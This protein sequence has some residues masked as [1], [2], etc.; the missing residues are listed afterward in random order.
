MFVKLIGSNHIQNAPKW[1]DADGKI[2]SNPSEETLLSHGYKPLSESAKPVKEGYF[3][4]FEYQ[5]KDNYIE[6]VWVEHEIEPE[7]E[8]EPVVEENEEQAEEPEP[9]QE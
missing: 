1:I 4:T 3:Y 6:K 9:E 5:E 7:P 2:Y 8:P